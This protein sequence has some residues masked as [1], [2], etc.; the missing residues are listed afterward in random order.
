MHLLED[1]IYNYY[2]FDLNNNNLN[3]DFF[4]K[5]ILSYKTVHILNQNQIVFKLKPIIS[6]ELINKQLLG[7][8]LCYWFEHFSLN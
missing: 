5:E 7:I 4:Y 1:L 3:A 8:N 6:Q 2:D